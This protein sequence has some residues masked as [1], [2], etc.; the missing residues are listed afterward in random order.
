ML[1]QLG[2]GSGGG[3]VFKPVYEIF[4]TQF[5]PNLLSLITGCLTISSRQTGGNVAVDNTSGQWRQIETKDI[6]LSFVGGY[7]NLLASS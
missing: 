1:F 6:A 5:N 4:G 3:K 7:W 2:K